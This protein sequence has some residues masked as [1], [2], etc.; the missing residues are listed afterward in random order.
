MKFFV[1]STLA[2]LVLLGALGT[3]PALGQTEPAGH[4][5]YVENRSPWHVRTAS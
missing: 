1:R 5:E 3:L 4:I 2:F